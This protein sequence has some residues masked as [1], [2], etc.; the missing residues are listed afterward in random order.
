MLEPRIV[1]TSVSRFA[2][3]VAS[4]DVGG[5]EAAMTQHYAGIGVADH[6]AAPVRASPPDELR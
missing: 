5:A 2:D 4:A 6:A 3:A 1:A